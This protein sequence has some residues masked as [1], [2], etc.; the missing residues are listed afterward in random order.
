MSRYREYLYGVFF[1]RWE[2]QA[3]CWQ[4]GQP[5][6]PVETCW[7]LVDENNRPKPSFF[8]WKAGIEMFK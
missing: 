5:D 3:V 8:A 4:C 1:Y 6:C 7:G 2:D